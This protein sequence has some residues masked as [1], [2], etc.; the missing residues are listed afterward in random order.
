MTGLLH[1]G[2]AVIVSGTAYVIGSKIKNKKHEYY[3][4]TLRNKRVYFGP[5][6]SK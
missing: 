1:V 3:A 6:I 5:S 4:V 2:L